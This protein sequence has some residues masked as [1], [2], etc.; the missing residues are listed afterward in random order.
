MEEFEEEEMM[1]MEEFE[2]EEEMLYG[3][4][5]IRCS[6]WRTHAAAEEKN[7]KEEGAPHCPTEGTE[8]N[9]WQ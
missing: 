8:C 6:L 1:E 4:A 2:E 9:L 7:E 5:D 3:E